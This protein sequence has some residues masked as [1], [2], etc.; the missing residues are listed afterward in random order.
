MT[1]PLVRLD[2]IRKEYG[3]VVAV[4]GIDLSIGRGEFVVLLG[5]SGSGKTTLLSILGGFIEPTAGRVLIDGEDVTGVAPAHRPTATVFQD[6]ALFPHLNVAGNVGFGLMMHKIRGDERERQ[7]EEALNLVGLEGFAGRAIHQLSGGQRQRVALARAIAVRP[8]V[9]LL[10]EPLGA[11]DLALRRQ[12]QDELVRIQKE[13][14]TT[15]IHVT[16]DQD[17]AMGIADTVVVLSHGRIEDLGSPRRV[18][19]QPATL[20][21]ATFMGESNLIPGTVK[22]SEGGTARI[23]TPFGDWSIPAN[24]QIGGDVWLVLRPEQLKCG[25]ANGDAQISLGRG[26]VSEAVFQGSHLRISADS[27]V[28]GVATLKMSLP[29]STELAEGATIEVHA[30]PADVVALDRSGADVTPRIA[31]RNE[32]AGGRT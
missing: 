10:D 1:D 31:S 25:A 22:D 12:M 32:R 20:F 4:A 24:A 15:F 13:L 5:P 30:D 8:T 17:E 18:Y 2:G 29:A 6:Y 27:P 19:L 16:H 7:I 14:G 3:A 9:L 11:L 23:A 21:A 26:T 28:D